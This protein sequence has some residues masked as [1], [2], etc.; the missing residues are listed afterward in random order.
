MVSW[1]AHPLVVSLLCFLLF[2]SRAD[3]GRTDCEHPGPPQTK[4]C[5]DL[6]TVFCSGHVS[7]GEMYMY[8]CVLLEENAHGG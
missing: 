6:M 1:T 3:S 5:T 7:A 2:C 4:T 8:V